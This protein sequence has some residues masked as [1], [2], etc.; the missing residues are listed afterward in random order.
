MSGDELALAAPYKQ[1]LVT[2]AGLARDLVVVDQAGLDEA[3]RIL[4]DVKAGRERVEE[5]FAEPVKRAFLAH[6]SILEL[7]KAILAVADEVD[8][9]LRPKVARFLDER[10]EARRQK[11]R[12]AQLAKERAEKVKDQAVDKASELIEQG[13]AGAAASVINRAVAKADTLRS[14]AEAAIPERVATA[15]VSVQTIWKSEVVEPDLVPRKY[16][17]PDQVYIDKLV[18]NLQGRIEIPGVRI[19]SEK[20]AKVSSK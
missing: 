20:I 17:K 10:D 11:E 7:K 19:W 1:E 3:A 12:E 6:R 14:E 9:V 16:C 5:A 2:L 18:R 4:K 15:G 8:V 13:H